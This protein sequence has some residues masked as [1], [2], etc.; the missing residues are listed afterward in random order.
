M[1]ATCLADEQIICGRET[2]CGHLGL[3]LLCYVKVGGNDDLA[4]L[5]EDCSAHIPIGRR[6]TVDTKSG[7]Q[8]LLDGGHE[9]PLGFGCFLDRSFIM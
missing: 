8:F 2:W 1:S 4:G 3:L 7:L 6:A 5:V 9:M